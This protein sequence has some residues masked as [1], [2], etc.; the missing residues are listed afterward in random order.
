MWTEKFQ[1]Y[2]LDFRK[3]RGT[4][5]QIANIC[6]I[7]EKARE[8]QKNIYICFIDY[9]KA[10]VWITTNC[11]KLLKRWDFANKGPYSQSYGFSSS[12]VWMWG[13]DHKEGWVLKTWCFWI[14]ILE[15]ILK[16]TLDSK[17]KPVNSKGN[18]SWIIIGRTDAEDEVPVLWPPVGKSQLI[19]K[20][21]MLRKI[22]GKRRRGRQRIRWLDSIMDSMD[23]SLRK[24]WEMVKDREAWHA[25]VQGIAKSRTQLSNWTT[26]SLR[27]HNWKLI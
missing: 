6:W 11:G 8:F 20:T 13:L 1:I 19:G 24:L 4:R 2:K 27:C 17:I 26:S 21:V 3:D 12:H 9:A 23:M 15:K 22:E 5:D 10:F 16:S 25:A 7:M 14:L 18:Q